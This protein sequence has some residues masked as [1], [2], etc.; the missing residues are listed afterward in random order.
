MPTLY[1]NKL[2]CSDETNESG[3]DDIYLV[4]V[5]GR[6]NPPHPFLISV[7]PGNYWNSM[8]EGEKR[9]WWIKLYESYSPSNLHS[10]TKMEKDW[11]IAEFFGAA[12]GAKS[13]T[14]ADLGR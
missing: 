7:G 14:S 13:H 11:G 1:A 9:N 2:R 8:E 6:P 10:V 5:V 12:D 3:P 4:C